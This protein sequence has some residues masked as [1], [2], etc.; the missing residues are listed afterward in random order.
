[1][2]NIARGGAVRTYHPTKGFR[3]ISA[4]R[5]RARAKMQR[6]LGLSANAIG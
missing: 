2:S 4:A 6:M 5:L 3:F 1:M